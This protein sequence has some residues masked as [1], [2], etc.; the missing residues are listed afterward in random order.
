MIPVSYRRAEKS[1]LFGDFRIEAFRPV[2][3]V[4]SNTR[5]NVRFEQC[6]LLATRGEI[7]IRFS[8]RKKNN[9]CYY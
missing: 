3:K 5:K 6:R 4:L 9:Y 2:E 8:N 7:E 1:E